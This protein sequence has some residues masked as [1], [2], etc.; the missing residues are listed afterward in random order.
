MSGAQ[1]QQP[2]LAP[3]PPGSRAGQHR[4]PFPPPP[5]IFPHLPRRPAAQRACTLRRAP[6]SV[7]PAPPSPGRCPCGRFH[8]RLGW[9]DSQHLRGEP[10]SPIFLSSPRRSTR[11]CVALHHLLPSSTIVPPST[12]R[13]PRLEGVLVEVA[14]GVAEDSLCRRR[15]PR[16]L[17]AYATPPFNRADWYQSPV[18]PPA[19]LRAS[20]ARLARPSRES[21]LERRGRTAR[22]RDLSLPIFVP[23]VKVFRRGAWSCQGASAPPS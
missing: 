7:L 3:F 2:A 5:P 13:C 1:L 23:T 17:K 12:G 6:P 20:G 21:P 15:G 19:A 22:S 14:R 18:A 4:A 8:C 10:S 9:L 16:Y 11:A